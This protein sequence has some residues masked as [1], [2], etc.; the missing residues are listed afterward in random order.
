MT[1]DPQRMSGATTDGCP[2]TRDLKLY[3]RFHTKDLCSVSSWE[4]WF[5]PLAQQYHRH[6]S[7]Q[8][9]TAAS[10]CPATYN[11]AGDVQYTTK[12]GRDWLAGVY[13]G[14]WCIW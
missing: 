1:H 12:R 7:K 5:D 6:V 4:P 10:V 14:G 13:S 3:G 8:G 11:D 2:L 9:A